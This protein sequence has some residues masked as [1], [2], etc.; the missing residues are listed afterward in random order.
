MGH[1]LIVPFQQFRETNTLQNLHG[2]DLLHACLKPEK[3]DS[4]SAFDMDHPN[5]AGALAQPLDQWN[6]AEDGALA[7]L[8][9]SDKSQGAQEIDPPRKARHLRNPLPSTPL[10]IDRR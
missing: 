7:D 6:T 1:S 9:Q 5:S 10:K 8:G 2:E 4:L 3:A